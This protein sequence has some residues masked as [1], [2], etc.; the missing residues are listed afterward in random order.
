[1]RAR[2]PCGTVAP[3]PLPTLIFPLRQA[4]GQRVSFGSLQRGIHRGRDQCGPAALTI[5]TSS[6]DPYA[7]TFDEAGDCSP[8]PTV[9]FDRPADNR[10]LRAAFHLQTPLSIS[11]RW[12]SPRSFVTA[13]DPAARVVVLE[14]DLPIQSMQPGGL[15][16]AT[17]VRAAPSAALQ[18]RR[19]ARLPRPLCDLLA[20]GARARPGGPHRARRRP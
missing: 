18:T 13:D 9:R 10:A 16:S 20:A 6:N 5:T 3:C 4:A 12:S 19:D 1:L 7:D 15:V 2:R 8:T 17:N 11:A 14:P